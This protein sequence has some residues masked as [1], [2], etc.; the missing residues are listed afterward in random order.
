MH[1]IIMNKQEINDENICK[2]GLIQSQRDG[3]TGKDACRQVW[4]TVQAVKLMKFLRDRRDSITSTDPCDTH[5][6]PHAHIN[7][8]LFYNGFKTNEVAKITNKLLS[9]VPHGFNDPS[10]LE[11]EPGKSM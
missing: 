11:A 2:R 4:Q 8:N 5:A 10:T 6:H 7:Y 9:L 1:T 3:F